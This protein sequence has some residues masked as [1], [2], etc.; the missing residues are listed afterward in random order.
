MKSQE[1]KVPKV[2]K[3]KY[4]GSMRAKGALKP[5]QGLEGQSESLAGTLLKVPKGRSSSTD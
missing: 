3:R 5:E 2:G 1:S 4:A